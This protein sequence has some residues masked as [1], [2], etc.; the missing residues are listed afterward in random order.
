M[1]CA[2]SGW[3]AALTIPVCCLLA[4]EILRTVLGSSY[5]SETTSFVVVLLCLAPQITGQ[6]AAQALAAKGAVRAN[7]ACAVA[8]IVV[9]AAGLAL[10]A[11]S[12]GVL[13]AA[14]AFGASMVLTGLWVQVLAHRA[15]GLGVRDVAGSAAAVALGLIAFRFDHAPLGVRLA[16]AVATLVAAAALVRVRW[17]RRIDTHLDSAVAAEGADA[18]ATGSPP[19]AR[20]FAAGG[21]LGTLAAAGIVAIAAV[22]IGALATRQP[23]AAAG[24]ASAVALGAFALAVRRGPVVLVLAAIA[25]L[26]VG[27]TQATQGNLPGVVKEATGA[28]L[29]L[30]MLLLVRIRGRL[31]AS[32][33]LTGLLL[34]LMA[35]GSAVAGLF[36]GAGFHLWW[37]GQPAG[38]TLDR[39]DRHWSRSRRRS[40]SGA[41]ATM[42]LPL[43]P[44]A[45]RA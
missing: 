22:C 37:L 38:H 27:Y 25:I 23:I 11:T 15:F 3:F 14:I 9:L 26:A 28:V 18:S 17:R 6:P 39:R 12:H 35:A 16:L 4:P 29:I 40:A 34:L 10:F 8:G 33:R 5:R 1:M 32:Q 45:E 41:T 13:G 31:T 30:G 21:T 44:R 42:G 24:L 19:P 36:G 20:V 2:V 43:A 7:A